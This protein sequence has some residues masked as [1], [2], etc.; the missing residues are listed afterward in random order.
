MGSFHHVSHG[1][2]I[3]LAGHSL[4]NLTKKGSSFPRNHIYLLYHEHIIL[5]I[6][7]TFKIIKFSA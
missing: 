4:N 7:Q 1:T 2:D 6:G 5:T 3:F